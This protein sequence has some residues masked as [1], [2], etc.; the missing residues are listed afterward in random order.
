MKPTPR[1]LEMRR[2]VHDLLAEFA[3]VVNDYIGTDEDVGEE[4]HP[5]H[6]VLESWVMNVR[7]VDLDPNP[8]L[9][10][11]DPGWHTVLHSGCSQP[12]RYGLAHDLIDM[13]RAD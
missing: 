3:D 5:R 12:M 11:P 6:P 2:R 10:E 4:E 7:W 9:H 13:L 1:M 8:E